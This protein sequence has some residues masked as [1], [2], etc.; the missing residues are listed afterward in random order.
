[1]HKKKDIK[2]TKEQQNSRQKYDALPAFSDCTLKKLLVYRKKV[3]IRRNVNK[4]FIR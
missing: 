4:K 1:M 3:G 2:L